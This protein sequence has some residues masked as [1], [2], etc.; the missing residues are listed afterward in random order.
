MQKNM[1][2]MTGL[3]NNVAPSE[4]LAETV[5]VLERD[6]CVDEAL[7]TSSETAVLLVALAV[8]HDAASP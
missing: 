7:L 3:L 8:A 5:P 1:G 4:V 2:H 6:V